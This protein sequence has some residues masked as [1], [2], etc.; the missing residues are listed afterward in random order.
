[1]FLRSK[2]N[3]LVSIGMLK[4]ARDPA[5]SSASF[6][7][8]KKSPGEFRLVVDIRPLNDLVKQ[9]ALSMPLI[10]DQLGQCARSYYFG[11]FDVLSGYDTLQVD[12]D[13]Q[14]YSGIVTPIGVFN[15]CGAPMGFTNSGLV[16]S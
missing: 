14:Q 4:Q 5:F 2:I 15:M 11:T 3:T 10:E 16:Y 1:E 13:S 8:P 6:V 12:E 9:S 7:V